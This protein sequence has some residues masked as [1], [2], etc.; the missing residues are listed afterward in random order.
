M[1]GTQEESGDLCRQC[2]EKW[3]TKKVGGKVTECKAKEQGQ[4]CGTSR[5]YINEGE[6]GESLGGRQLVGEDG[7]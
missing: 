1:R 7:I 3:W 4:N 5:H 2:L 6:E